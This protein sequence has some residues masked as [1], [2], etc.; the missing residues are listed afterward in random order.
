MP[1]LLSLVVD[2]EPSVRAYV[3]T[4]LRRDG[5]RVLEAENGA[6]ALALLRGLAPKITLLVS[7]ICMPTMDGVALARAVRKEFPA[8]PILLM[9][10][11]AETPP[12]EFRL[13]EKPFTATAFLNNIRSALRDETRTASSD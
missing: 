1:Q 7:D 6:E 10:G 13:I 8:I 2:D 9:T 11:Y 5:F 12:T 4:L 3:A